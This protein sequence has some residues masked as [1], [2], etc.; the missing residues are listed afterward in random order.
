MSPRGDTQ[1]SDDDQRALVDGHTTI[2]GILAPQEANGLAMCDAAIDDSGA[3]ED[4]NV[5][6]LSPVFIV[7]IDDQGDVGISGDV[8]QPL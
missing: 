1:G 3:T 8:L 4:K 5:S 2:L 7:M 6:Q